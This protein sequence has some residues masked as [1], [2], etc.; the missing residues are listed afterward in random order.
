MDSILLCYCV[1]WFLS[2]HSWVWLGSLDV[3]K[4][5]ST[6]LVWQASTHLPIIYFAILSMSILPQLTHA[7]ILLQSLLMKITF[8]GINKFDMW[9]WRKFKKDSFLA[10]S[11]WRTQ[12]QLMGMDIRTKRKIGMIVLGLFGLYTLQRLGYLF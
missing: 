2:Y 5:Q 6:Q 7:M 10:N 1:S 12:L 11:I 9:Y 4:T 3:P 8:F